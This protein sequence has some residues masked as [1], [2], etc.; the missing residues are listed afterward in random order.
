MGVSTTTDFARKYHSILF[1]VTSLQIEFTSVCI[2][3][4]GCWAHLMIFSSSRRPPYIIWIGRPTFVNFARGFFNLE[5][6][7]ES[8]SCVFRFSG[9][10]GWCSSSNLLWLFLKC[11]QSSSSSQALFSFELWQVEDCGWANLQRSSDARFHASALSAISANLASHDGGE[12]ELRARAG[13]SKLRSL[14]QWDFLAR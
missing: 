9:A 13:K 8:Q 2:V 3:T 5:A 6:R 4:W 1:C 7:L 12:Q 11:M 14:S 10:L